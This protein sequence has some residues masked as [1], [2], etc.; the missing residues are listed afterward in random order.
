MS[1]SGD[2]ALVE[3]LLAGDTGGW[4]EFELRHRRLA[5]SRIRSTLRRFGA[6]VTSD[7]VDDVYALFLLGLAERDKHRLRCFES[8]R[9]TKLSTWIGMLATNCAWDFARSARRRWEH[10]AYAEIDHFACDT[11][12]PE[13]DLL[14]RERRVWVDGALDTLSHRDRDLVRFYY[15]DGLEPEAIADR[16]RISVSTVYSKKHKLSQ[17]LRAALAEREQV[18]A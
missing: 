2:A 17:R 4:A 16:M 9:G 15:V 8:T 7:D 5:R 10:T 3:R 1:R 18:A 12:D 11:M 14:D 6:R 13:D